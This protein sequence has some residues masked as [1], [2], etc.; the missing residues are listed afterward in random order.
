MDPFRNKDL[1]PAVKIESRSLLVRLTG[2][3]AFKSSSVTVVGDFD[4]GVDGSS[5]MAGGWRERSQGLDRRLENPLD[6][7]R[8]LLF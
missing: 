4:D 6:I 3:L 8:P 5:L 1:W 2:S 7:L